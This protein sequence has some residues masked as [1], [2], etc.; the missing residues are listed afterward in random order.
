MTLDEVG[1][2]MDQYGWKSVLPE[3]FQWVSNAE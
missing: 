1:Y 3:S 2:I